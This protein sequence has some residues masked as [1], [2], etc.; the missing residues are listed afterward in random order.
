MLLFSTL[1]FS[2]Q[3]TAFSFHAISGIRTICVNHHKHTLCTKSR[4]SRMCSF[5][6]S[7]SQDYQEEEYV[8]HGANIVVISKPEDYVK[9]LEED[10]R[11]C[12]IKFY[13]SWCKSCAKFGVKYRKL[14][15]DYGDHTISTTTAAAATPQEG[16]VRFAEVEFNANRLLCK[17]LKVR[18]LPTVHVYKRGKGKVTE[19]VKRPS[20]FQ[21]VVDE[22][23]RLLASEE[24]DV[25]LEKTDRSYP[26]VFEDE[27]LGRDNKN[28][29]DQSLFEQTMADG[30]RLAEEIME[31]VKEQEREDKAK[32]E[33]AKE[34]SWFSF[35]FLF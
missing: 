6:S 14:A 3:C 18:S 27:T 29:T 7:L 12:V 17:T 22:I 19:M 8:R 1:L 24:T 15:R 25:A 20:E 28:A 4:Q 21:D 30:T 26:L 32:N 13:A 34:K 23:D 33:A 5:L 9:F 2:L 11:L 16:K 35:P 10:D 31:K